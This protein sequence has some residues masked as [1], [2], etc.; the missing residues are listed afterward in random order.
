[1][2]ILP[3]LIQLFIVGIGISALTGDIDNKKSLTVFVLGQ[4][5]PV[6]INVL[7]LDI[8]K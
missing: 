5:D 8:I 1:M 3:D 6:A 4:Q 2:E 7:A